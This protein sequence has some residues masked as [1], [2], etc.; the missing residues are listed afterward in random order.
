[1]HCFSSIYVHYTHLTKT[2]HNDGYLPVYNNII[3][4]SND[5]IFV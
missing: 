5:N 1:M 2:Q 3:I 4:T